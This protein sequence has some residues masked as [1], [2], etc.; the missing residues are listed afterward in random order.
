MCALLPCRQKEGDN[1]SE[2]L[3]TLEEVEQDLRR[4]GKTDQAERLA[5]VFD[6]LGDIQIDADKALLALQILQDDLHLT[7]ENI[8][9]ETLMHL[10]ANNGYYS[11]LSFIVVDYLVKIRD[12]LTQGRE[13]KSK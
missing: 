11:T 10:A 1:M 3:T 7:D 8:P 4:E 9:P 5:N 2:I 6:S 12:T 13:E